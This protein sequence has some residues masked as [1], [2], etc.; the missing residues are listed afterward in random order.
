M[1][2]VVIVLT[3]FF[4]SSAMGQSVQDLVK[5]RNEYVEAE[6]KFKLAESTFLKAKN[7]YST[8]IEKSRNLVAPKALEVHERTLEGPA[9]ARVEIIS[10]QYGYG[11][12]VADVTQII[13]AMYRQTNRISANGAQ[14]RVPDPAFGKVKSLML[15]LRING[16]KIL[17]VLP[18]GGELKL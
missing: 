1:K 7:S 4:A 17:M 3:L 6:R 11:T 9:A 2:Y 18:E 8:T 16:A 10:A 12:S 15:E 5:A 13:Q 14:L